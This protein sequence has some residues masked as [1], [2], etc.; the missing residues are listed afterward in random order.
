MWG[1]KIQ[2]LPHFKS[3]NSLYFIT[4]KYNYLKSVFWEIQLGEMDLIR[5]LWPFDPDCKLTCLSSTAAQQTKQSSIRKILT[6]QEDL[7]NSEL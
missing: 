1:I 4:L 5:K 7:P 2:R 3:L 6:F